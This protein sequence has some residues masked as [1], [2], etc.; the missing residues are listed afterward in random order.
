MSETPAFWQFTG[1]Y[2]NQDW[3]EIHGSPR[4]ALNAFIQREPQLASRMPDEIEQILRQFATE[5]AL[6]S[7]VVDN[8]GACY[9]PDPDEGGYR[10]WLEAVATQIR[11][12][13]RGNP[14]SR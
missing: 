1:A 8:Q 2:L 9:V 3:P 13:L 4:Q 11:T 5:E 7:Y 6:R 12:N 10:G 14:E